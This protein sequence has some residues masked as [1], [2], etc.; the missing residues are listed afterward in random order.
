MMKSLFVRKPLQAVKLIGIALVIVLGIGGFFRFLSVPA[1]PGAP[2]AADSQ[3]LVIV[4][5]PLVGLLLIGVVVAETLVSGVRAILGDR[6][7]RQ[8]ALDRPG[9]TA[10]RLL[11]AGVAVLAVVM[12]ATIVPIILAESTPAPVGVGAMLAL[13]VVGLVVLGASLLRAIVE[14]YAVAAS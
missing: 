9:Y 6:S 11:E 5:I 1:D 7:L 13:L 12:M 8:R 3:L 2:L 4:G 14:L 10:V